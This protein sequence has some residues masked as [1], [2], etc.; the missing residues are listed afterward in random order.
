[1]KHKYLRVAAV[2]CLMIATKCLMEEEDQP[3]LADLVGSC[4]AEFTTNDLKRMELVVL[5]KLQW[6]VPTASPLA[7]LH[8]MTVVVASELQ[9]GEAE[10]HQLMAALDAQ[11]VSCAVSYELLRFAPSTLAAALLSLELPELTGLSEGR[12]LH[13]V[14]AEGLTGFQSSS[15]ALCT[16]RVV[17]RRTASSAAP[18]WP[19]ATCA[20][21]LHNSSNCSPLEPPRH[22]HCL[23]LY[24]PLHRTHDRCDQLQNF[25]H[26]RKFFL[27]SRVLCGRLIVASAELQLL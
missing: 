5:D 24:I 15:A 21:S 12:W 27:K 3:L 13:G 4:H 6:R 10:T 19:S 17:C 1:M 22:Y 23:P 11:F 7:M 8:N 2:A 16:S 20:S 25:V 18:P 9:L 26:S 14:A